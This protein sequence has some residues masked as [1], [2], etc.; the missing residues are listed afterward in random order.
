[1]RDL[2]AAMKR[3]PTSATR[4]ADLVPRAWIPVLVA[5]LLL[6]GYTHRASGARAGRPRRAAARWAPAREAQ[7]P[8]RRRAG[9]RR[10]RPDPGRGR[11]SRRRRAPA[12]REDT[13][14]YNAGTAAL[15]AGRLDVARGAL[16]EAA[17]S[18]DPG[19]RYRALYNLGLVGLLAARADTARG[20][21]AARTTPADRLRQALLLAAVVRA[22]Q[23]EPGARRAAPAPATPAA[24][25]R[26]RRDAA[27]ER[28]PQ[29]PQRQPPQPE[30]GI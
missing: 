20:R 22:R 18:L 27:A 14:F 6:L 28:R 25:R 13:A 2:V 16:A 15:H 21:R 3:S 10:R 29:A 23:V 5:A 19:L 24:E 4:T 7:R 26:R 11:V 30:P 9:A 12:A 8:D 17:K 1:M